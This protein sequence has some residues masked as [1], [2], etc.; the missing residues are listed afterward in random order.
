MLYLLYSTYETIYIYKPYTSR[1]ANSEKYIVCSNFIG[2]EN[3]LLDNLLNVLDKWNTYEDIT[4][5]YIFKTIPSDFIEKIKE[6]NIEIIDSQIKSINNTID[7]IKTNKIVNDKKW[8]D[9]TIKLQS[10][11]AIQWCK[12]YN[13]A[14][15]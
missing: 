10:Q 15:N 2:I 11:K 6:I 9:A 4:I 8:Y 5:N 7:I 14:Y 13:I 1:I 12:K 3:S